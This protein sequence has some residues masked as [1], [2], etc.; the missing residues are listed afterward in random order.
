MHKNK[1]LV[2]IVIILGL[3]IIVGIG[4]L[5]YGL[6]AKA[7]NPSFSFFKNKSKNQNIIAKTTDNKIDRNI[8]FKRNISISLAKGEW[9]NKMATSQNKIILH[10]TNKFKESRLLIL[11]AKN[12][13]TISHVEFK[14]HK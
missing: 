3:L 9:V 13:S 7:T 12:G 8:K 6:Y 10:I 2:S 4:S 5:V 11:D 14:R 1:T